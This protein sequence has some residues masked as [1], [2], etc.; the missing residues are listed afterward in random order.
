[1]APRAQGGEDV[2]QRRVGAADGLDDQVAALE[3]VA[4]V[5]TAAGQN[6]ADLRPRA[7][8]GGDRVRTRLEQLDERRPDRAAAQDADSE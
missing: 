7:D 5:A 6:P 3:D 8:L 1:V 4:E 2:P